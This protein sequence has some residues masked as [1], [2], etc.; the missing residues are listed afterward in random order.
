M[1]KANDRMYLTKMNT[2]KS[3][4]GFRIIKCIDIGTGKLLSYNHK[5]LITS[6]V[7]YSQNR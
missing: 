4:I 2:S 5:A 6:D 1:V 7:D 3:K